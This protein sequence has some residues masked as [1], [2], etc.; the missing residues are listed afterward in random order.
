MDSKQI[1]AQIFEFM[2][3]SIPFFGLGWVGVTVRIITQ[4][5]KKMTFK[6]IF[7][8]LFVGGMCSMLAGNAAAQLGM[9]QSFIN[10][11]SFL[12][13]MTADNLVLLILS[14]GFIQNILVAFFPKL[15]K[16]VD[17]EKDKEKEDK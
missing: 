16:V 15:D 7:A 4:R 3:K 14:K 5:N 13:G 17:T 8:A 11:I 10:L 9:P 6:K 1:L 12:V 2:M